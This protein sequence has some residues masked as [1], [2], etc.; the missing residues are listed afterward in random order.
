MVNVLVK[1][2]SAMPIIEEV[3]IMWPVEDTGKNSVR[4]STMAR[5]MA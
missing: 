1:E 5:I 4:P 2:S 3:M